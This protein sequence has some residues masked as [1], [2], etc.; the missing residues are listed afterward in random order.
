MKFTKN[1][2]Y[3]MS[4][5]IY[6]PE[7]ICE[8][9]EQYGQGN[10]FLFDPANT[11]QNKNKDYPT[12][13][14]P[15]TCVT[16][17]DARA[18]LI[19]QFKKQ[20]ISS[21]T[22]LAHGQ[23]ESKANDVRVSYRLLDAE[24]FARSEYGAEDYPAEKRAELIKYNQL[25]IKALTIIH[26][27]YVHMVNNQILKKNA[28]YALPKNK[29]IN[30]F[31]Q[32]ERKATK[33]EVDADEKRADEDKVVN[34]DN[35]IMLPKPLFRIKL[36]V[37]KDRRIGYTTKDTPFV[38]LVYDIRKL[39]K[40]NN[41]KPVPA[42]VLSGGKLTD[43]TITNVGSFITYMSQT[44]GKIKFSDV[45][46]SSSGVSLS[47]SFLELHVAPHK[48]LKTDTFSKDDYAEMQDSGLTNQDDIEE[49]IDEPV[50]ETQSFKKKPFGNQNKSFGK[51]IAKAS[52]DDEEEYLDDEEPDETD[53]PVTKPVVKVIKKSKPVTPTEEEEEEEDIK[54]VKPV[55][56]IT[57]PTVKQV[58]KVVK[59]VKQVEPDEPDE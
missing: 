8:L 32:Y 37:T 17:T 23:D 35:K 7:L 16:K 52:N 24:D 27:E 22:K 5:T 54:P 50:E 43:L 55:K 49:D 4:K 38:P 56:P 13:Y 19:Y 58:V 30:S 1:K 40:E 44:G 28:K 45:C 34:A 36:S 11:K 33:A 3:K 2:I 39:S 51:N 10:M 59:K 41:Y 46:L 26:E 42:K 9:R 6:T 20:I 31:A 18:P 53:E 57:K 14:I 12:S 25:H 29:T 48:K 47:N 15:F 21:N